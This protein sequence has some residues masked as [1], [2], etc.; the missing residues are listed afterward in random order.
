MPQNKSAIVQ[1]LIKT[2]AGQQL[3]PYPT[4][5]V[6]KLIADGDLKGLE[7]IRKYPDG[8]WIAI[9][10]EPEFYDR[11]LDVLE[12]K[13]SAPEDQDPSID[14][15][16]HTVIQSP[17]DQTRAVVSEDSFESTVIIPG[18][19]PIPTPAQK[20]SALP[21]FIPDS[22]DIDLQEESA[23]RTRRKRKFVVFSGVLFLLAVISFIL[24]SPKK[25]TEQDGS[26]ALN[27]IHL[28]ESQPGQLNDAQTREVFARG[29]GLFLNDQFESYWES[30][31]LMIEVSRSTRS[32]TDS[33]GLLCLIYN[34]LWPY[35][36]R[37]Q[38]DIE[39]IQKV[40]KSVKSIDP[41]GINSVYCDLV[42]LFSSG[43]MSEAKGLVDYSLNQPQFSTAP[44]LYLFKAEILEEEK[45]L[46]TAFLYAEKASSLWPEWLA[47]KLVEARILVK[48]KEF[49]R[50]NQ[51]YTDI[52]AA[53]PKHKVAQIE[54]ALLLKDVFQRSQEAYQVLVA[55][56][57]TRGKI[58][59]ILEARAHWAAAELAIQIG[60]N[61]QA[62]RFITR[63]FQLSP[64]NPQI[65]KLAQ[66]LGA[67][68]ALKNPENS[69]D[70]L[71]LL[72]DQFLRQGNCLSAQ[73]EFKAAFELDP[74]NG[75]AA[76][77]AAQ[78]LWAL[79]QGAEALSWLKK[80]TEASPKLTTAYA[81]QA[82]YL[83]ARF[84]FNEAL[85][86][87]NSSARLFP[88][89][90]EILRTY[91][92]VEL[93]RNNFKDALSFLQRAQKLFEADVETI[94][95]LSQA[96]A[97]ANDMQ[98]AQRFAVRAIELD[99]TNPQ[100]HVNYAKVLS[101]SRG[102]DTGL[103]YLRD[104]VTRYSYTLEY[105]LAMAD[106][107]AEKERFSE[108]QKIYE[109]VLTVDSRHK[110]ARLGLGRSLQ[111]QAQLDPA[112]REFLGATVIDPSDPEGLVLAGRL[113]L[114][115]NKP[116]EAIVQFDRA[117]RVNPSFP[118][119]NFFKGQAYFSAGELQPALDAAMEERRLNPNLADSY[120]LAAEI[121]TTQREFQK[122][123]QE[124]Q[125]AVKL[126]PQGAELYVRLARCHRQA[127][128]TDVAESMLLIAANQESGYP[129]IYKEQGAIFETKGDRAAA[130]RAYQKYL[131]LSPNAP[132]RFG[133]ESKI[134]SLQGAN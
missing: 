129:E 43:K 18:A 39:A 48:L 45:S 128:N 30:Q 53:N 55:T 21:S 69:N 1:W 94:M 33:R 81:L 7:Q 9:S 34:K 19:K 32:T 76:L 74:K 90:H 52:L 26:R 100:A 108:A 29:L 101:L 4:K 114:D 46:D 99:G 8:L 117:L 85:V 63:A 15:D 98:S 121:Y 103:V 60:Q 25:K 67:D 40:T 105:R 71:M 6:M 134:T 64:S 47:P 56:L 59:T 13:N 70:E 14:R 88:N 130:V 125:Q 107:L 12:N 118:R 11:I 3:G 97:G 49:N 104:L 16:E 124:Y 123:A 42:R 17:F 112:L 36:K 27:L 131:G 51:K 132:D 106:L 31:K 38:A 84:N 89:N 35:T 87:L 50:A 120:I 77:K 75:L 68:T 96:F 122:C 82:D 20:S 78:C 62:K 61:E 57:Q 41:I 91:G 119:V 111:A 83:S 126:R 73:A 24:L 127:G 2:E 23:L 86:V 115:M 54:Q 10:R 28:E 79:N 113:Y 5:T 58:P 133:I 44:V 92:L 66:S 22:E 72:G 95:Y 102:L 110:Q 65:K 80:A 93:R 116:R 37:D 109:Q